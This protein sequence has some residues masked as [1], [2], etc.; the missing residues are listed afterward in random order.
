MVNGY[1]LIKQD[2]QICHCTCT[3]HDKI[4][5]GY[6]GGDAKEGGRS[7]KV[8]EGKGRLSFLHGH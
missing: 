6:F 5:A 3:V 8:R 4:E 7:E 1:W 2:E